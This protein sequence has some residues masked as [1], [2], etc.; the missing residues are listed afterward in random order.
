MREKTEN[1]KEMKIREKEAKIEIGREEENEGG[2]N[3]EK[4]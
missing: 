2:K 1:E 4:R 3:G